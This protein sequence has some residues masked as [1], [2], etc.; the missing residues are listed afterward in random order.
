MREIKVLA[1]AIPIAIGLSL[2]VHALYHAAEPSDDRLISH[3]T[4]GGTIAV[5]ETGIFEGQIIEGPFKISEESSLV[6]V[7]IVE[8]SRESIVHVV[9]SKTNHPWWDVGDKIKL[10]RMEIKNAASC[11]YFQW[12]I[13][14]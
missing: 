7:K 6:G 9:Y 2:L 12:V 8:S 4:I 1:I 5:N 10:R 14:N 3:L 13:D 11:P